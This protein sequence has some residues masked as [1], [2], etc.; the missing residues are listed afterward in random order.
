MKTNDVY[1]HHILE[2]IEQIEEYVGKID[3]SDFMGDSM[4]QDAVV[5]PL[6]IVGEASRQL[7]ESFR[8]EHDAIPWHAIIG[9]RNRIAHDYLDVDLEVVWDVVRHDLP[10]LKQEV[11]SMLEA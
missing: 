7:S 5:R 8:E 4:R 10:D 9:M 3:R 11:R 6:E 2:A 1:L